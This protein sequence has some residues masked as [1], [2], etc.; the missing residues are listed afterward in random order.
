MAKEV[1]ATN[2]K[3]RRA[4]SS[5]QVMTEISVSGFSDVDVDTVRE[6]CGF[7][8]N[9]EAALAKLREYSE[10]FVFAENETERNKKKF[11]K[12]LKRAGLRVIEGKRFYHLVGGNDKGVAVR[13]LREV[14]E[15]ERDCELILVGLGDST[16]DLELLKEVDIPVLVMGNNNRYNAAVRDAVRPYLAGAPGPEGWKRAINCILDGKKMRLA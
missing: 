2:G 9:R 6:W 3:L 1:G 14:L 16:N 8:T 12:S 4:L 13:I 11:L 10:P 5:T 15:K 7:E